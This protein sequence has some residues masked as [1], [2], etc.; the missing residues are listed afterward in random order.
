MTEARNAFYLLYPVEIRDRYREVSPES[1]PV[2]VS[3]LADEL[4]SSW[5][6]RVAI[7]NGVA[8]ASFAETLG[9]QNGMWS[10]RLDVAIPPKIAS[11]LAD[12]TG[13]E[14][15]TISRMSFQGC[16]LAA[17]LLPL[18]H[19][20]KQRFSTWM[21]YCP[22]CLDSDEFPYFRRAWR[23][24]T[25]ISCFGH[26][27]GLRDRCPSCRSGIASFAQMHL[28]P[29]HICAVCGFDLCRAP[30]VSVMLSARRLERFIEAICSPEAIRKWTSTGPLLS[31]VLRTPRMVCGFSARPLT[32]LS[33]A[34]RR[35]C[36][37]R[38]SGE[39]D[40]YSFDDDDWRGSATTHLSFQ[41]E[42]MTRRLLL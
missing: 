22:D 4:L 8:P 34:R 9:L 6:H 13:I 7:A 39:L 19:D 30:K 28:I 10:A 18:R 20:S 26:R 31:Q 27:K 33:V 25:R 32:S 29:Q 1:W 21:Q 3:P 24:A 12:R 5:L 15:E 41:L 37:E 2:S 36:F 35:R 17:L 23:L 40:D 38:L 14:Q 16:G 11:L 42:E